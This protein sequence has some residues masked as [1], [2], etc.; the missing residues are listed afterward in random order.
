MNI[1]QIQAAIIII[2]PIGTTIPPTLETG[3]QNI[4]FW[5]EVNATNQQDAVFDN[6]GVLI[7]VEVTATTNLGR[8]YERTFLI[9]VKQL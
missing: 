6:N 9:R 4:L 5:V 8:T 2:P 7:S 1:N 3:D